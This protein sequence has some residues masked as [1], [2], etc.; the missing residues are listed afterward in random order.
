MRP[1]R[2]RK[3]TPCPLIHLVP[4]TYRSQLYSRTVRCHVL[5]RRLIIALCLALS[6]QILILISAHSLHLTRT[7]LQL[8][9]ELN[10]H[11]IFWTW[12]NSLDSTSILKSGPLN[13]QDSTL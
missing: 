8:S 6:F 7:P 5:P 13:S 12:I 4:M 1:Q 9:L 11:P 10:L 3:D 2:Q